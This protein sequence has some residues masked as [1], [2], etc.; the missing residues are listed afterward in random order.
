MEPTYPIGVGG[1][2]GG[3]GVVDATD[4]D[5]ERA[6]RISKGN[7]LVIGIVILKHGQIP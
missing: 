5:E 4:F 6:G 1:S 3:A 2:Q 7:S